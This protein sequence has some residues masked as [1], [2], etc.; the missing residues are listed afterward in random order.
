MN[1]LDELLDK[2]AKL[3]FVEELIDDGFIIEVHGY[4]TISEEFNIS[5]TR[6]FNRRSSFSN[7]DSSINEILKISIAVF[8]STLKKEL[9][10]EYNDISTEFYNLN[11]ETPVALEDRER[12]Y[13]NNLYILL[14]DKSYSEILHI[15]NQKEQNDGIK[16]KVTEKDDGFDFDI[17][18]KNKK[19][20]FMTNKPRTLETLI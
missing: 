14:K 7:L 3:K 4:D 1:K 17:Y 8:K 9:L 13:Y 16:F 5:V 2:Q 6:N 20:S 10:E 12:Q 11:N 15:L 19:F 18:I